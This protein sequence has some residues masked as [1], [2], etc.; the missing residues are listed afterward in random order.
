MDIKHPTGNLQMLLHYLVKH[1]HFNCKFTQESSS[2]KNLKSVKILQN[3]GHESVVPLLAHP[4]VDL[5]EMH[6]GLIK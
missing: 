4:V 1:T 2:G 5:V 3:Y 6:R